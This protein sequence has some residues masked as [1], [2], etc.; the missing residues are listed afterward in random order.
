MR[1]L[2]TF[3]EW[4]NLQLLKVE[5]IAQAIYHLV[6]LYSSDTPTKLLL[7]MIIEYYQLE[8]D[9]DKQ[10]FNLDFDS[11]GILA[12][13]TWI[14]LLWQNISAFQILIELPALNL[15]IVK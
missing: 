10:L 13:P 7:Q 11:Y 12:T 9:T 15:G 6:S 14:T 5:A 3:L 4:L 1:S 8:I 2:L